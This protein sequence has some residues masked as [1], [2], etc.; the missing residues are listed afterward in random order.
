MDERE[1]ASGEDQ[2]Q[3]EGPFRRAYAWPILWGRG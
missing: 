3:P 2:S 1:P